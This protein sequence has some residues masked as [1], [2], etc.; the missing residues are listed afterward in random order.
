M[1]EHRWE[2]RVCLAN[3]HETVVP[4]KEACVASYIENR[5]VLGRGNLVGDAS[6]IEI[7]TRASSILL[8][9]DMIIKTCCHVVFSRSYW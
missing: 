7:Y 8:F 3:I 1:A 4:R 6:S 5:S 2:V 9:C